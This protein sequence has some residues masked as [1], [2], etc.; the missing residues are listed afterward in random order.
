VTSAL[1]P[2]QRIEKAGAYYNAFCMEILKRLDAIDES[3]LEWE[4]GFD[5]PHAWKN[6]EFCALQIRKI[7][8]LFAASVTIVHTI[9]GHSLDLKPWQPKRLLE[10]VGK[11]S[12]HPTPIPIAPLADG[13]RHLTPLFKPIHA[14]DIVAVY[15]WCS[16]IVHLPPITDIIEQTQKPIN[17]SNLACWA[18]RLRTIYSSHIILLPD[19]DGALVWL[20]G[21]PARCL[22]LESPGPGTFESDNLQEFDWGAGT[23]SGTGTHPSA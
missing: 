12:E 13:E 19:C 4:P 15:R 2:A 9:F 6:A 7:C 21:P 22:P 1:E 16:T 17:F 10:D 20:S 14:K 11:V 8:E 3:L 18:K 23:L 5:D